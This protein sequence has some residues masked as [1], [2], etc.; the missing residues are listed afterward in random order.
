MGCSKKR[1]ENKLVNRGRNDEVKKVDLQLLFTFIR[2]LI[3]EG[4][5]GNSKYLTAS[6][7]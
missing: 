4:L 2:L 6:I 5:F 1:T 3:L 7:I